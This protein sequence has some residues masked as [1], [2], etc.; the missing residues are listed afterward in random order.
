[1]QRFCFVR[2]PV[3]TLAV[4]LLTAGCS[5]SQFTYPGLLTAWE[6]TPAAV[7]RHDWWRLITPLFVHSGGWR[8]IC[9]NFPAILVVGAAAEQ[10]FGHRQWLLLYFV[11]GLVGEIAGY[12]WQ[13]NGAGASVAGAGLLGGCAVWMLIIPRRMQ[14]TIGA[15]FILAG[16]LSL[17][18]IKD[19]HGPPVLCGALIGAILL[20]SKSERSTE[21]APTQEQLSD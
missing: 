4:V 17:I 21:A 19:L 7:A 8:Q 2:R 14:T 10:I 3:V 16:A 6:R 1:M 5:A 15:L 9:F 20:L 12:A 13:P 11:P 18:W